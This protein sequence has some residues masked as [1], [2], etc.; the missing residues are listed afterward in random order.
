MIFEIQTKGTIYG[1]PYCS[2]LRTHR[3]DVVQCPHGM[4]TLIGAS[5]FMEGTLDPVF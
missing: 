3:G 4:T 1:E 5:R 2:T